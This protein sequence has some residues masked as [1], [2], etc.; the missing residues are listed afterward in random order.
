MEQLKP[1]KVISTISDG[2]SPAQVT[3][4]QYMDVLAVLHLDVITLLSD[5]L[6][7]G[8][9][10]N[11][12]RL[13]VQRSLRWL[14]TCLRDAAARPSLAATSC[15]VRQS[16]GLLWSLYHYWLDKLASRRTM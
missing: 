15:L 11:R 6:P 3:P 4:E 13:A 16:S 7:A 5:E 2:L 8:A 12:R 1:W 14:D 9:G 10:G